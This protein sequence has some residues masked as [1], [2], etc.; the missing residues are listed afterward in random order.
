MTPCVCKESHRVVESYWVKEKI[1]K[2]LF[3]ANTRV[4]RYNI[5]YCR[6]TMSAPAEFT[7]RHRLSR[8][9][10]TVF[11]RGQVFLFYV[12]AQH[13]YVICTRIWIIHTFQCYYTSTRTLYVTYTERSTRVT[14]IHKSCKL[15]FDRLLTRLAHAPYALIHPF[16]RVYTAD[17][18][19]CDYIINII[20]NII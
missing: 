15:R 7:S 17:C 4:Q 13:V 14:Y 16:T 5:L 12:F 19:R 8:L 2:S 20:I 18:T 11:S 3:S 6:H 10:R 1:I 9:L